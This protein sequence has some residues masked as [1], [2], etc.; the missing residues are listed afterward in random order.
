MTRTL[1][2][3][4]RCDAISSAAQPFSGKSLK[5]YNPNRSLKP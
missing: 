4:L 5:P 3:V 2:H 1:G